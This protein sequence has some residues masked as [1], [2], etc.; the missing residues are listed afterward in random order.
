MKKKLLTMCSLVV[1]LIGATGFNAAATLI[2]GSIG[3]TGGDNTVGSLASATQISFANMTVNG[4]PAPTGSF[5]SATSGTPVTVTMNNLTFNPFVTNNPLW[6]FTLT[7]SPYTNFYFDAQN[8]TIQGQTANFLN[9]LGT[10]TAY[11]TGF[12]PTPY[13]YSVTATESQG[14]GTSI[15]AGVSMAPQV[16]P[17]PPSLVML[18]SGLIGLVA[19]RRKFRR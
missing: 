16:V 7:V 11:G 9:I 1:L 10:G 14:G 4:S 5:A 8:A 2:T 15:T 3:F 17:V 12:T 18:S 19:I 13:F 6:S